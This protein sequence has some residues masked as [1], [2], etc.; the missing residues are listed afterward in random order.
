MVLNSLQVIAGI[1]QIFV[2]ITSSVLSCKVFCSTPSREDVGKVVFRADQQQCNI[3]E[4]LAMAARCE[5][6]TE[7]E[8]TENTNEE[9]T[10]CGDETA[11]LPDYDNSFN[12]AKF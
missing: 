10:K 2:G 4:L 3:P 5:A 12:Y 8:G 9:N 6:N 11:S 1:V 7:S